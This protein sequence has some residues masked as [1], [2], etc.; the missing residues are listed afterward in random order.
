MK[1]LIVKPILFDTYLAVIKN[2]VGS[3]LFRNVYATVNGKKRDIL[4]GGILGCSFF[5]SSLLVV[6]RLIKEIH[7]TVAGTVQDMERSG[8]K[9]TKQLKPGAII[10]WEK[11][12]KGDEYVAEGHRHLGFYIGRNLAISN[13][14]KQRGPVV[15]HVTFGVRNGKAIRGIE[16]IFWHSK[17]GK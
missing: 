17:L 9:G 8:W 12:G 10:L 1:K 15:H 13:S 4:H 3:R 6:L 2:S 14:R 5:V 11:M 16:K 7:T